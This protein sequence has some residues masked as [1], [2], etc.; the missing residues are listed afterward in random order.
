MLLRRVNILNL[1]TRSNPLSEVEEERK[2]FCSINNSFLK[3]R[4]SVRFSNII[5]F[6]D[7]YLIMLDYDEELI[8][9]IGDFIKAENNELIV[10]LKDECREIL[11]LEN[12][13][14][15]EEIKKIMMNS[16]TL[17]IP[18][19]LDAEVDK[20]LVILECVYAELEKSMRNKEFIAN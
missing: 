15:V 13:I 4:K 19:N 10:Q 9:I 6:C 18:V 8:D 17:D 11:S 14:K 2:T 20:I 3:R 16:V 5:Y 12:S 1:L 7:C